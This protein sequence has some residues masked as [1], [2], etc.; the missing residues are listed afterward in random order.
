MHDL[1]II[2]LFDP[3]PCGMWAPDATCGKPAYL[4]HAV[5]ARQS[6]WPVPGVWMLLPVCPACAQ[7][8]AEVTAEAVNEAIKP[9]KERR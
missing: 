6:E 4:A 2:R 8:A 7:R 1:Q 5:K 3:L 9:G